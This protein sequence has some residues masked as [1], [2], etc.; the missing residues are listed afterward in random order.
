LKDYEKA[1]ENLLMA[2]KN[3][4]DSSHIIRS[5]Y[6]LYKFSYK[7]DTNL[8]EETLLNALVLRP[9]D[10]NFMIELGLYYKELGRNEDAL[11]YFK[12][13]R[14]KATE[15]KDGELILKIDKEIVSIEQI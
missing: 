5:L 12:K 10:I 15:R 6:E 2:L 3:N 14:D 11:E 9:E 13:A 7:K 8:A 4:P 1:E